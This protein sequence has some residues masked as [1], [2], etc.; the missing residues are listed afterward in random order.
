MIEG[1][2]GTEP[3]YDLQSRPVANKKFD[4]YTMGVVWDRMTPSVQAA[5]L[6]DCLQLSRVCTVNRTNLII[7]C[8][9]ND[10]DNYLKYLGVERTGHL[11]EA[12]YWRLYYVDKVIDLPEHAT[13]SD[14]IRVDPGKGTPQNLRKDELFPESIDYQVYRIGETVPLYRSPPTGPAGW[15]QQDP[16]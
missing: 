14:L 11:E 6:R 5:I 16:F 8:P 1:L 12:T 3:Q 13:M 9:K 10:L 15:A 7:A 2:T 4:T